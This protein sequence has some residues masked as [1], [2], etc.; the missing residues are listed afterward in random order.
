[1]SQVTLKQCLHRPVPVKVEGGIKQEQVDEETSVGSSSA[2]DSQQWA[3]KGISTDKKNYNKF[4][5]RLRG[6]SDEVKSYFKELSKSKDTEAMEKFMSE[7]VSLGGKVP[8]DFISRKRKIVDEESV[9]ELAGWIAWEEAAA[10]EGSEALLAMVTA[11]TV[12]S[13]RHLKLPENSKIEFPKNLQ[14]RFVSETTAKKKATVNEKTLNEHEDV[15]PEC[16]EDFVKEFAMSKINNKRLGMQSASSV[17]SDTASEGVPP[18]EAGNPP[19]AKEK[20]DPRSKVAVQAMRKWHS[21]WDRNHREFA[22][23]IE[24]SMEHLNTKGCKFEK[25]LQVICDECSLVDKVL[26][27]LEQKFLQGLPFTDDD[28]KLGAAQTAEMQSK[29]KEG[30]KKAAALRPWFKL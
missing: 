13:R 10:K 23:L 8:D 1:M 25:D 19:T 21:A 3:K 20:E 5:Y 24:K 12:D 14:I 26:V 9:T 6:S 22:A 16:H 7:F 17:V 29:I 15:T 30:S 28:I 27:Q 2:I 11:G 4:N 18:S